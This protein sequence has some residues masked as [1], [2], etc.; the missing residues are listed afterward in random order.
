MPNQRAKRLDF[1]DEVG[2]ARY[3]VIKNA[4][5]RVNQSFEE[6]YF[7]EA[8]TILESLIADRLESILTET[9]GK[10]ISFQQL[11]TLIVNAKKSDSI[12]QEFKDSIITRLFKWKDERN[13]A[14][15]EMVKLESGNLHD[16][17]SRYNSFESTVSNGVTLFKELSH[18]KKYLNSNK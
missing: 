15:H 11:G 5:R 3:H 7:L 4:I 13:E 14:L 12:S 6:G 1:N 16:W 9:E 17:E 8:I 2:R 10:E 18:Y